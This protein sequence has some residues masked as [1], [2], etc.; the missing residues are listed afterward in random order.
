MIT[1]SHHYSRSLCYCLHLLWWDSTWFK[2]YWGVSL[3]YYYYDEE[4]VCVSG[5]KSHPSDLT[6]SSP[7]ITSGSTLKMS[8]PLRKG[9][10][11]NQVSPQCF[12]L[13]STDRRTEPSIIMAPENLWPFTCLCS[14]AELGFHRQGQIRRATVSS[15]PSLKDLVLSHGDSGENIRP[16]LETLCLV[17]GGCPFNSGE[18]PNLL[19]FPSK[20]LCLSKPR[21][22]GGFTGAFDASSLSYPLFMKNLSVLLAVVPSTSVM[23]NVFPSNIKWRCVSLSIAV[24]SSRVAVRL[25]CEDAT[26]V[27]SIIFRGVDWILT[28][29]YKVTK[30]QVSGT[31]MTH[32]LTHSNTVSNSLSFYLRGFSISSLYVLLLFVARVFLNSFLICSPDV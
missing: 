2:S 14:F 7:S 24:L 16:T 3:Y 27:I 21:I 10:N 4:T 31:A 9:D 25:G 22:S 32:A 20:L 11:P 13:P 1:S 5:F 30:S 6:P 15:A 17:S 18:N 26:D 23:R 12:T 29:Q 19:I 8:F 28:S